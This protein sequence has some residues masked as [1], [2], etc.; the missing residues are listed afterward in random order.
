MVAVETADMIARSRM[1]TAQAL[2]EGRA[3]LNGY[4][5]QLLGV[6]SVRAQGME[7]VS[8]VLAAAEMLMQYGWDLVNISKFTA[9]TPSACAVMRRRPHP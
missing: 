4:P 5:F 7:N 3:D 8:V 6:Y 9:E 2:F 1:I